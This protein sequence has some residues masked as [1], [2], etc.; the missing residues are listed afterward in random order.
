MANQQPLIQL[1]G[2]MDFSSG[3]NCARIPTVQS[4]SNPHGLPRTALHW[5][6]NA[7]IRGGGISPRFGW[8]RLATIGRG[9]YQ[10][11]Y[12]Y[13]PTAANPYLILMISGEMRQVFLEGSY[14]ITNLS[15]LF[16][17]SNP[18]DQPYSY[19]VQGEEF[20]AIQAGDTVT[21]PLIWEGTVLRRS[22]GL[23]GNPPELPASGPMVYYANR[24]WYAQDRI[25]TAGDIARGAAGT[26][27]YGRRDSVI[28]VTENPLAIV[29]DGFNVPTHAGPIRALMYPANIDTALG[30]GPLLPGTR[31]AVFSLTVPVSRTDWTSAGDNQPGQ[32]VAQIKWGPVS[33]RSVVHVNGDLFYQ[34]LEPGIRSLAFARR[35]YGQ[36]P[37]VPI[38]NNV[39]RI[40]RLN[41]RALL[42]YSSGIN[43]DNRLWQTALPEQTDSGVVHRALLT[44]DFDPLSSMEEQL[45]P[46][47]EGHSEGLPVF[48]M[49]EG[50][51]GGLQRAF[52]V[53]LSQTDEI[54]VWELT[55][56][57]QFENG[58]NRI[59]WSFESPAFTWSDTLGEYTLKRLVGGEMYFD[60]ITG[61]ST[62]TVEYRPDS[63]QCWLF[64]TRF[65][66]CS[67]RDASGGDY[68]TQLYQS[69]FQPHKTLPKP[70]VECIPGSQ[71]PSDMGL[72]FQVRITIKGWL[73]VRSLFLFG[74]PFER[75]AY[76]GIVC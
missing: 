36:W 53:I 19:L 65:D 1:D 3:V 20:L 76:H 59:T 29:G 8:R 28:R 64:W 10:G 47:W 38:S 9:L 56:D 2:T 58:D 60:Q 32:Q 4:A 52:A 71:R 51:F 27:A 35:N 18:I 45:P 43:W 73:R 5:M 26:V 39:R 44:L 34:T 40:T 22:N 16:G 30:Q 49:F 13:E 23:S 72:Q 57:E 75:S 6:T 69:G 62:V 7:T 17:L 14:S 61:E 12:M 66:V 31:K 50:D 25:Y 68:P 37:N 11:G 42:R 24:I 74:L 70:P 15:S 48:Q 55:R 33:D 54:E 41:N 46:V 63:H 67:A 21:L